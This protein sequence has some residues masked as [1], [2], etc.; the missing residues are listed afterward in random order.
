MAFV[1][2]FLAKLSAKPIPNCDCTVQVS[3]DRRE[4][5][6]AT[7]LSADKTRDDASRALARLTRGV[8]AK[9]RT[10]CVGRT[11]LAFFRHSG[12]LEVEIA[13]DLVL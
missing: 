3:L 5:E 4:V 6:T 1:D 8:G 9:R 7:H 2:K 11:H 13:E 10:E 12:E